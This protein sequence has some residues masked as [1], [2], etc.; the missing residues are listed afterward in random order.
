MTTVWANK[1]NAIKH[2]VLTKT[3]GEQVMFKEGDFIT[4][5]GRPDGVR[6][7]EIVGKYSED[8]PR[9]FKYLPWRVEENRWATPQWSMRGDPRY[10]I[11]RPTGL[12]YF[13]QHIDWES[14][15]LGIMPAEGET[16]C[17]V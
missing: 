2:V 8:G 13:G 10:V 3:N 7:V 16:T 14:V 12:P 6:I 11:C 4:Y 5:V 9:G 17:C 15:D 1:T